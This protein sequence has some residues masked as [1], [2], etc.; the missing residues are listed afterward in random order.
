M[1]VRV[2]GTRHGFCFSTETRF[3]WL[4]GTPASHAQRGAQPA[5]GSDDRR[6]HLA[7]LEALHASWL[8]GGAGTSIETNATPAA[9][10]VAEAEEALQT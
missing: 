5:G 10:V 4:K 2:A 9:Q 8:A 7:T 1:R 3:L 6:G